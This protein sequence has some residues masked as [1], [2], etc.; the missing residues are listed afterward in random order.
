MILSLQTS[1]GTNLV[2]LHRRS[3]VTGGDDVNNFPSR[4]THRLKRCRCSTHR[5][6]FI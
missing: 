2:S 1:S 6:D 5:R 3:R 4:S